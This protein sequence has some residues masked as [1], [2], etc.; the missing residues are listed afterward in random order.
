MP[1]SCRMQGLYRVMTVARTRSP[2]VLPADRG[3]GLR[4]RW[5]GL[6][7]LLAA[8]LDD[9]RDDLAG[10]DLSAGGLEPGSGWIYVSSLR[11]RK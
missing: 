9:G 10:L 4:E 5:K 2:P 3:R 6:T 7:E 8:L 11:L 1:D